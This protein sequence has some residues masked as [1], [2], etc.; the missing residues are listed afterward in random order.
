M[1]GGDMAGNGRAARAAISLLNLG[2][3]ALGIW[4]G[5]EEL[6]FFREASRLVTIVGAAGLVAGILF[7]L[8]GVA[9][10]RQRP[11]A[12]QFGLSA[13]VTSIV[14]YVAGVA[15]G[16]IGLW[17]LALGV[18]YPALVMAWLAGPGS[19]LGRAAGA[20]RR[21]EGSGCDGGTLTRVKTATA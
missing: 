4:G 17:G 7:A 6:F 2:V 5:G 21:S 10:W 18:A 9:I 3:G 14:V 19:G 15:L 8:A 1:I 12:R 13:S 20:E 16:V 11:A